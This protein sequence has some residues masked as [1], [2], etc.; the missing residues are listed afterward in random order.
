MAILPAASL[1]YKKIQCSTVPQAEQEH[2]NACRFSDSPNRRF[3]TTF[4]PRRSAGAAQLQAY[5]IEFPSGTHGHREAFNNIKYHRQS[6][7]E[8]VGQTSQWRSI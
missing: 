2:V 1:R 4:E 5:N 3:R 7:E 8:M 6:A